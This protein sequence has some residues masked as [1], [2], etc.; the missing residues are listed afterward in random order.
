[1]KDTSH[2]RV[3][4]KAFKPKCIIET[5]FE[6]AFLKTPYFADIKKTNSL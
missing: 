6:I 5:K 2:V 1:M 3:L 4:G